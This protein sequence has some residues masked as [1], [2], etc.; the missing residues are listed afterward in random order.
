MGKF[1]VGDR[2]VSMDPTYQ[3]QTG[4]PCGTVRIVYGELNQRLYSVVFDG[5]GGEGYTHYERELSPF[6]P[7]DSQ[8]PDNVNSHSHNGGLECGY[9][10]V[11]VPAANG[12]MVV[13]ECKDIVHALKLDFAEGNVFKELFR[14]G[15][16][17]NGNGK[18]GNTDERAYEKIYF[19][20]CDLFA[21]TKALAK[22]TA[23]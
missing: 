17:R 20:A 5:L 4:W 16:A 19:F 1:K 7:S 6:I 13:V 3:H 23:V 8:R 11:E 15:N 21:R 10:K 9:Y 12:E 18:D 22:N 14:T 2:V